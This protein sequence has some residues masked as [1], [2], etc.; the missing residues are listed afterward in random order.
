[1]ARFTVLGASGFVGGHL[2]E[3]LHRKGH[4]VWVPGRDDPEIFQRDLGYAVYCIGVIRD[5]WQRPFDSA[6]AH[7]C[8]LAQVLGRCRFS[9]LVYLSTS[10]LYEGIEG[11]ADET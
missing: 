3:H 5:R 9:R 8:K 2:V 6:E 1:M 11:V 4:E 10:R 7:V